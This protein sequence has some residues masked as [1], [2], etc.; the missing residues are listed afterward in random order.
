ME[1]LGSHWTDVQEIQHLRIF[2]KS[3]EKIEV[4]LKSDKNNIYLK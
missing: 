1:Q 2:R 4:L 3:F